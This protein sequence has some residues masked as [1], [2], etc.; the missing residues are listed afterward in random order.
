MNRPPRRISPALRRRVA[1]T[2]RFRCGYCLTSQEIIG[3][4]LEIDHLIPES[5]GG[6]NDEHNLFLACP[7]CNSHKADRLDAIDPE[8]G[9]ATPLFN[10]RT[11]VWDEHFEWTHEAS[12]IGGKT[13]KGR[14]TVTALN[15][16]HPDIVAARRLWVIA[17]WHP[18]RA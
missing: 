11:E 4:L 8:T 10:P 12:I 16:N 6:T 7:M 14:A 17:G 18:P 9:V 3:P 15:M 13:A 2:A 1:E 5:R